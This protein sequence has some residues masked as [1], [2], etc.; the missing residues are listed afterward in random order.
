MLELFLPGLC[1][2]V[3]LSP[4]MGPCNKCMVVKEIRGL[5]KQHSNGE[6]N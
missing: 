5:G 6:R 3:S 2:D 1:T 4:L